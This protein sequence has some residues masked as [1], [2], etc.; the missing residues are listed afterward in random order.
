[1]RKVFLIVIV[2]LFFSACNTLPI[3]GEEKNNW[4]RIYFTP[5]SARELIFSDT[6][7]IF[8]SDRGIYYSDDGARFRSAN[9][10]LPGDREI[11]DVAASEGRNEIYAV[12]DLGYLLR[13]NDRAKTFSVVGQ[14]PN[15]RI[16]AVS[17]NKN[18]RLFAASSVGLLLS[19][20]DLSQAAVRKVRSYVM[21]WELLVLGLPIWRRA[22]LGSDTELW[23]DWTVV[24]EGDVIH[25]EVDPKHSEH[26]IAD[27]FEHGAVQSFDEGETWK[28]IISSES[29]IVKGPI[30]FG[31][32]SKIMIGLFFSN[33]DGRTWHRTGLKPDADDLRQ[34]GDKEFAVHDAAVTDDGYWALNYRAASIYFS[35]D[36][37]K[38]QRIG[39]P[40][41]FYVENRETSPSV[42]AV[43]NDGKIWVATDGHGIFRYIFK[44]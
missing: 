43:G 22:K 25:L 1:M 41:N 20:L 15:F 7:I 30:A 33:D 16:S 21:P 44:K 13:S 23:D 36:A 8:A 10:D 3:R 12:T 11:I 5:I 42:L 19:D 4:E 9:A 6:L 39:A 40:K 34:T 31:T 28:P 38:W 32:D 2:H 37:A 18:G 14:F 29:E 35:S 24:Y 27:V 17:L 26:I